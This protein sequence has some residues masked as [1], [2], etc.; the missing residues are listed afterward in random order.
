M[1]V[2]FLLVCSIRKEKTVSTLL[3]YCEGQHRQT[4]FPLA[5]SVIHYHRASCPLACMQYTTIPSY[6]AR[7]RSEV[8]RGSVCVW[9]GG[10]GGGAG[11]RRGGGGTGRRSGPRAATDNICFRHT[12]QVLNSGLL[13]RIDSISV[14]S[15][16]EI[17][18]PDI[19]ID[20]LKVLTLSAVTYLKSKTV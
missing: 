3:A 6:V 11:G 1:F 5:C 20:T 9:G 19:S 15:E 16:V 17:Q 12:R 4:P 13:I 18:L 8:R 7:S 14:L 2:A 10:G